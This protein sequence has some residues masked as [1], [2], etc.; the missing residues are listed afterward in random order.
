MGAID[1][2]DYAPNISSLT[3]DDTSNNVL[4]L[5][6]KGLTFGASTNTT[7]ACV[8]FNQ[9]GSF[10][11]DQVHFVACGFQ[12]SVVV[13]NPTAAGQ[14]S[15]T[16]IDFTRCVFAGANQTSATIHAD[17]LGQW[18]FTTC[19]FVSYKNGHVLFQLDGNN[20]GI[21]R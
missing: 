5:E 18:Y 7:Q 21:D 2:A 11:I 6:F 16:E 15:P 1:T 19:T 20:T 4:D 3:I 10:E 13:T 8:T 17:M 9:P 12:G 14:G